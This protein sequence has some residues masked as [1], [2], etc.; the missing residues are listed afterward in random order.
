MIAG[1]YYNFI[2][3]LSE[4][5]LQW[6]TVSLDQDLGGNNM[7]R[8]A[9]IQ[10]LP[11]ILKVYEIARKFMADNGNASQWG[12]TF[13]PADLL[14]EDI[15]NKQLYVYIN[16]EQIHGVFAFIL[17]DDP[18]YS[19]IE[20]G[21]WISDTGYGTIHRVASD[22]AIKGIL[23]KCLDYCKRQSSH[24]RID[25]HENNEI[26]KHLIQK[27]GFV[28]CGTIYAENGSPRIAFEYLESGNIS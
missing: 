17:G 4:N 28:K 3:S 5:L 12:N 22:G 23:S 11:A 14:E 1:K 7:I 20:N 24:L 25:T 27:N 2:G 18:T 15:K 16:E 6:I 9:K 10:E 13:P 21:S 19:H 26:M 8:N